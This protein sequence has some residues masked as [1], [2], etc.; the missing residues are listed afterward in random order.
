MIREKIAQILFQW[1]PEED[2]LVVYTA[3]DDIKSWII[4][5]FGPPF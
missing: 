2:A 4:D 3:A 1:F 5:T